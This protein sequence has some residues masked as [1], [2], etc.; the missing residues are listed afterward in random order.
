M[1][2]DIEDIMKEE[3]YKKIENATA[4][5]VKYY[6]SNQYKIDFSKHITDNE[7]N[8]LNDPNVNRFKINFK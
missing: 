6:T 8:K 3:K 1:F 2:A 5:Q 7:L 4:D